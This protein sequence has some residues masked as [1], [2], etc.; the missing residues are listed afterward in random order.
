MAFTF[1]KDGPCRVAILSD[2]HGHLADEFIA[3]IDG[4]DLIL[5]A[6]DL[7]TPEI[8]ETLRALAP[9]VAV[10]GNMDGGRW[11]DELPV[12]EAVTTSKSVFHIIH[13]LQMLEELC[14]IPTGYANTVVVY[15]HTH[16]RHTTRDDSG[17]LYLN[18]GSATLPRK[19]H[20]PSI[21]IAEL[22]EDKISLS[23][24]EID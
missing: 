9:T 1:I 24:I 17:R 10:R 18:P 15:G 3:A 14:D 4:C 7:N 21:A 22:V 6:G 16:I 20:R 5:H 19:G 11:A 23:P 13:D 12:Y 8:L 2:T